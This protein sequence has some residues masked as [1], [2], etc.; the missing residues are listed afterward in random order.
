MNYYMAQGNEQR[1]PFTIEQLSGLG[2][3]PQTLVWCEGMAQWQPAQTV[4]ELQPVVAGVSVSYATPAAYASLPPFDQS[5]GGKKVAAGIC[6]ILLGAFGVHKFV[7]GF[8]G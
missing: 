3:R 5:V 8:V 2:L 4:A 7:L 1:G 6:G